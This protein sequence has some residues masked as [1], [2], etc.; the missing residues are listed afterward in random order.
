MWNL[1]FWIALSCLAGHIAKRK[2]RSY[3][4]FFCL[5]LI[6]PIIGI[7]FAYIAKPNITKLEK[8]EIRSGMKKKCPDCAE[9]IKREA[10]VC[11]YCGSTKL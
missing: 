5:S 6:L 8:R 1:I 4:G 11:R 9:I 2:G 10:I 7:I 3:F